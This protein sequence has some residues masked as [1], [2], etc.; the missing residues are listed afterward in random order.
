MIFHAAKNRLHG[1]NSDESF[2]RSLS[3]NAGVDSYKK[4]KKKF[5]LKQ[6][7]DRFYPKDNDKIYGLRELAGALT[8]A[9]P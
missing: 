3:I 2:R 8:V 5:G 6:H 4:M 1:Q 9:P 7:V